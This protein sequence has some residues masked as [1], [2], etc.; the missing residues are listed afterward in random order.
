MWHV[1]S[2]LCQQGVLS[3]CLDTGLAEVVH[4]GHEAW[5]HAR[6]L[7]ALKLRAQ[8]SAHL[9]QRLTRCPPHLGVRVQ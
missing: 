8:V 4:D 7:T 5:Q 9:T 6:V 1:L 2:M 3:T